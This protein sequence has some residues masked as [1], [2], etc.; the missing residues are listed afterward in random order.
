MK[1]DNQLL[2]SVITLSFNFSC[3]NNILGLNQAF[4]HAH[5]RECSAR[6]FSDFYVACNQE[7]EGWN[8]QEF[9]LQPT[10]ATYVLKVVS[11]S[12]KSFKKDIQMEGSLNQTTYSY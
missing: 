7:N 6:C 12:S 4:E 9:N 3:A 11:P 5:M 8:S 1:M 10:I 2:S